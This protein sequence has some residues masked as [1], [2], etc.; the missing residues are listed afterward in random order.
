MFLTSK[1]IVV[2]FFHFSGYYLSVMKFTSEVQ[3]LSREVQ[4]LPN[5]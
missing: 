2:D 5:T 3:F 4:N 1:E